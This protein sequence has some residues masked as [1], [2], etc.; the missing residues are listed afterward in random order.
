MKKQ[1]N[2]GIPNLLILSAILTLAFVTTGCGVNT[3]PNNSSVSTSQAVETTSTVSDNTG[4]GMMGNGQGVGTGLGNGTGTGN[5][6]GKNV[7]GKVIPVTTQST[8]NNGSGMM[9]N[10]NGQ[11]S[12]MMNQ[13]SYKNG[14]YSANGEYYAEGSKEA[15]GV[16]L[17][18]TNDIITNASVTTPAIDKKSKNYQ[19]MFADNFKSQVVGKKIAD[20]RL[21]RVA[22]ASLTTQGFNNAVSIIKSQATL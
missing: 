14:S 22:G 17:T 20:L 4:V 7:T 9:G 10:G 21:S 19:L 3:V 11:G 1:N 16:S 2:S 15:I 5:V 8:N 13:Y 6:Q 12:G 18:L